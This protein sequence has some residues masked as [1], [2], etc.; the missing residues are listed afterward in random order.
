M[1]AAPVIVVETPVVERIQAI[2]NEYVV[3]PLSNGCSV[4]ALWDILLANISALH[5][6][7]GGAETKAALKLLESARTAPED[8]ALHEP[9]IRLLLEKYYDRAYVQSG[10]LSHRRIVFRGDRDSC[11]DFLLSNKGTE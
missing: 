9:W 2:F 3:Q 4:D 11:R 7:L 8:F 5:R 1:R 6:R 10:Q